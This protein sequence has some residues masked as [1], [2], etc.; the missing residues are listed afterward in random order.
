MNPLL[1]A[2]I[3]APQSDLLSALMLLDEYIFADKQDILPLIDK[4][5]KHCQ[6]EIDDDISSLEQVEF[7]IENFFVDQLFMDQASDHA[8]TVKNYRLAYAIAYRT[9]APALKVILF[10]HVARLYGFNCDVVFIPDSLMIR[11]ICADDYVIVFDIIT[12][13]ALDWQSFD[14]RVGELEGDPES[15][16]IS[17]E[18]NKTLIRNYLSNLKNALIAENNYQAALRCV[19]VLLAMKPNDPI[20]RRDRGFLLHQLDCFKVAYDDYRYFVEQCPD[21]PAAQLLKLQ[22]NSIKITNTVLH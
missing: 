18:N 19:D 2:E 5:I 11:I 15:L 3:S 16:V 14:D 12:G 8:W 21:D 10:Q 20:E 6:L 17:G 9:A 13:E 4:F 22:L 1:I 7:F